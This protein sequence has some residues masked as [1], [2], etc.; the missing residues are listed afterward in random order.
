MDV[1]GWAARMCSTSFCRGAWMC[2]PFEVVE[3]TENKKEGTY[4]SE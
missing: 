4:E 3:V 1:Q 2:S